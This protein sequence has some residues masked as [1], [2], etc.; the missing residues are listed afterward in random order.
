M[1][2]AFS[3]DPA[4]IEA[5]LARERAALTDRIDSLRQSLAPDSLLKDAMQFAVGR[6][7]P[8]AQSVGNAARANPV[9]AALATVGV[10]WLIFGRKSKATTAAQDLAET[11]AAAMARWEN[12]GGPV[13]GNDDAADDLW[14]IETD[15]LRRRAAAALDDLD[16]AARLRL[17]PA[18]DLARERA[19][20]IADMAA[21]TSKAMLRG[22]ETLPDAIRLQVLDTRQ[23]VYAAKSTVANKGGAMITDHP[24]IAAAISL[25]I[26]AV[27]A[28]ILPLT[29]TGHD[30]EA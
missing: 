13:A 17:R 8:V 3:K 23:R 30:R 24:L 11:K 28:R 5:D 18:A 22:L 25:A 15:S 21:S 26:G 4:E 14:I 10:A 6:I 7:G 2:D 19:A 29:A 9:A 12:E 16:V 20:V 27:V 1:Y